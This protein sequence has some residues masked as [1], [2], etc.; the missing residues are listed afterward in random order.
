MH[1]GS[2]CT[3][4]RRGKVWRLTVRAGATWAVRSIASGLSTCL[5]IP[6][7]ENNS[8]PENLPCHW[9]SPLQIYR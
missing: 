7:T 9:L 8:R 3:F 2:L 4:K 5:S 1:F 6:L